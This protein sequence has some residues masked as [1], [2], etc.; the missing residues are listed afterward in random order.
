MSLKP[1]I[2]AKFFHKYTS[3]ILPN[4]YVIADGIKIPVPRYYEKLYANPDLDQVKHRR[5][6]YARSKADNNTPERLAVRETVT[7]AKIK[8]LLRNKI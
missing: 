7:Q 3:D 2:G 1:G 5:E 4:D 8:S 6:Q